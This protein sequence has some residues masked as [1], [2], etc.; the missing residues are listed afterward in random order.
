MTSEPPIEKPAWISEAAA[1][2][3]FDIAG[4][5]DA[6]Q[7]SLLAEARNEAQKMIKTH[8]EWDPGSTLHVI[9]AVFRWPG[10]AL[11]RVVAHEEWR[12]A[13]SPTLRY[14]PWQPEGDH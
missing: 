11:P 13:Y 4:A 8:V 9:G 10:S 6:L 7:Q 1:I 12:C 5:I 2:S 14:Q 3:M